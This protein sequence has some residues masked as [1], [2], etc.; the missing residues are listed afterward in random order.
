MVTGGTG[1]LGTAVVGAL[2]EAGAE[3]HVPMHEAAAPEAFPHGD[4]DKLHL[5]PGVALDDEDQAVAFYASVPGLWASIQI[6]GGFAMADLA[7]TSL[8]DF[9]AMLTMNLR[10]CFLSCREA[11]KA[12]RA[13]SDGEGGRLV[14]IAARPAL[15]PTPGM[16]AY[17]TA[18][19]GV[20]ALTQALAEE[21]AGEGIWVNAVAPG[22][23]DTPDNREAM[24]DADRSGWVA[25]EAIA[26]T[27]LELASPSNR[28]ARGAVVPVYG[29][30]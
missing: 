16:T 24:P 12:M 26:T 14:N 9:D 20:A 5:R 11:V 1:A 6:A 10:T 21:L 3:V 30:G 4:H 17:A 18:K 25:P 8:S 19:S 28:C 7:D 15:V 23:I 29:R 22:I 27:I 2:L 13:R